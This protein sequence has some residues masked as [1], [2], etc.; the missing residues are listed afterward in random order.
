[1]RDELEQLKGIVKTIFNVTCCNVLLVTK[2]SKGVLLGGFVFS[3]STSRYSKSNLIFADRQGT[4]ISLAEVMY[5]SECQCQIIDIIS[6]INSE[7]RFEKLW[8]IAAKWHMD[9]PCKVWFGYPSQV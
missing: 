6:D 8:V 2:G 7:P 5:F 4:G 1:M 9:H 3:S